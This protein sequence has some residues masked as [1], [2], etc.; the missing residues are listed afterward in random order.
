MA[1]VWVGGRNEN[2][3][4][5][6]TKREIAAQRMDGAVRLQRTLHELKTFDPKQRADEF[7]VMIQPVIDRDLRR[8][9]HALQ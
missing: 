7:L 1:R 8:I 2:W 6:C 9:L 3:T 4:S 5:L